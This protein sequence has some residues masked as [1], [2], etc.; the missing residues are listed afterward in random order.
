MMFSKEFERI[1]LHSDILILPY[2]GSQDEW[3]IN[4]TD[5]ARDPLSSM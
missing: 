5:C 3:S 2:Q 1:S 4:H